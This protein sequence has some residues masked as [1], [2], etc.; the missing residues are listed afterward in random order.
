MAKRQGRMAALAP[1]HAATESVCKAESPQRVMSKHIE[2]YDTC[3]MTPEQ[4]EIAAALYA[5]GFYEG[6]PLY[7]PNEYF[8]RHNLLTNTLPICGREVIVLKDPF[9]FRFTY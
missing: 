2:D 5:T 6:R 7:E 4:R 8:M 3:A 9:G 1:R